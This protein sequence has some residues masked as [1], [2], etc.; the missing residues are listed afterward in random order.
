MDFKLG[1][2]IKDG[3]NYEGALKKFKKD[4]EKAGILTEIKRR[5]FFEKP[6]IRR[7]KKSIAARKRNLKKGLRVPRY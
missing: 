4:C 2:R 3:D 7:K 5:E 6:S 1:I